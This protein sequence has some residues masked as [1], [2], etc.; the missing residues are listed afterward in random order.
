MLPFL[1][2]S[3]LECR[4]GNLHCWQG[5]LELDLGLGGRAL[6][7]WSLTHS[8]ICDAFIDHSVRLKQNPGRLKPNDGCLEIWNMFELLLYLFSFEVVPD[9]QLPGVV[10]D[11]ESF[12]NPGIPTINE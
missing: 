5:R 1:V 9:R 8:C 10:K 2:F 6:N 11:T 4:G 7:F 3:D 12:L